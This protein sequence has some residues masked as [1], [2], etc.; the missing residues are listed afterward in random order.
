MMTSCLKQTEFY[1]S[2]QQSVTIEPTVKYNGYSGDVASRWE[3]IDTS[4]II[5]SLTILAFYL[6]LHREEEEILSNARHGKAW[7][8]K[9]FMSVILLSFL[10]PSEVTGKPWKP[11]YSLSS[12]G[13]RVQ[14]LLQKWASEIWRKRGINH[15]MSIKRT[16]IHLDAV[17]RF[18]VISWDRNV[19]SQTLYEWLSIV[20]QSFYFSGLLAVKMYNF[21]LQC[22]IAKSDNLIEDGKKLSLCVKNYEHLFRKLRPLGQKRKGQIWLKWRTF[23]QPRKS[24]WY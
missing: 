16:S 22:R 4:K 14:Y 23:W 7:Q 12:R 17:E 3:F 21:L 2:L 10:L 8:G 1:N 5:S 19:K 6:A 11:Y 13:R 24:P 20:S 18:N 9:E 15:N